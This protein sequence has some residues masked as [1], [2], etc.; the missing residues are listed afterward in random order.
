MCNVLLKT[1]SHPMDSAAFCCSFVSFHDHPAPS[2]RIS[3]LIYEW[4]GGGSHGLRG[5]YSA[6][7]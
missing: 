3:T 6:K 1:I 5:Q 2:T 4:G 7:R